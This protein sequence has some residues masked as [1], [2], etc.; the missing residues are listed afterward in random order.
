MSEPILRISVSELCQSQEISEE[1]IVEVVEYGIA[2][3]VAGDT[4]QEWVF[5]NN[6]VHWMKKAIRLNQQLEID[7]VAV[8]MLIELLKQKEQLQRENQSLQHQ[9]ARFL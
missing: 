6:S 5:D 8:A 2:T 9:L 7:W 3:P 1:V 4:W